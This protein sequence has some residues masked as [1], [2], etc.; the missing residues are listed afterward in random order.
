MGGQKGRKDEQDDE[1]RD[2][3]HGECQVR[4]ESG[5]GV[6]GGEDRGD[7]AHPES[8]NP[9]EGETATGASTEGAGCGS[10]D[11]EGAR[12]PE[13]RGRRTGRQEGMTR[14]QLRTKGRR[15]RRE[16]PS[17]HGVLAGGPQ[18]RGVCLKVYHKAP[19][20]PNSAQ[21]WVTSLR[22]S[23]GKKVLAYI[24]GE[25]A[26]GLHEHSTVLIRGGRVRDLPGIHHK[27]IRGALDAVGVAQRLS[28]RSKYGAVRKEKG[29]K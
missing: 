27:V 29:R 11:Q 6:V 19:K 8:T 17:D 20:K 16:N 25:G 15:P 14:R 18:V 4:E 13:G 26:H 12:D 7:C 22:R 24:P 28:S 3:V 9:I 2:L 21:R 23:T 10:S 5:K 1:G